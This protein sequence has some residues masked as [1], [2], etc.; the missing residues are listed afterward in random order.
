Y[1]YFFSICIRYYNNRLVILSFSSFRIK[2]YQNLALITGHHRC[3]GKGRNRAATGGNSIRNQQRITAGIG[4]FIG[5]AY[6]F[7]LFYGTEIKF[8]LF[9]SNRGFGHGL[10]FFLQSI[11]IFQSLIMSMI[12]LLLTA[13]SILIE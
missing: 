9:K 7:A 6:N 11:P 12:M 8:I 5:M 3:F 13:N 2:L 1:R 4:K 10:H